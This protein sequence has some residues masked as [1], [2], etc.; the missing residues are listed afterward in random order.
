M[1]DKADG[2]EY[3]G[4]FQAKTELALI[5][6][7]PKHTIGWMCK[8]YSGSEVF[9]V[10]AENKVIQKPL[11]KQSDLKP[12]TKV[13]V[14]TLVGDYFM[15]IESDGHKLSAITEGNDTLAILKFDIDDRHCWV[16]TGAINMRGIKKANK[17]TQIV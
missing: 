16:S 12:G 1:I 10:D 14:T 7:E 8:E 15:T 13:L 4:K 11:T 2:T 3:I 9:L 5:D 17:I 6:G